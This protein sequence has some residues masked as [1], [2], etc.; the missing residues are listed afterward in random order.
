MRLKGLFSFLNRT[1]L[2][3][4]LKPYECEAYDKQLGFGNHRT[5]TEASAREWMKMYPACFDVVVWKR[6]QRKDCRIIAER[7]AA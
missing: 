2:L 1:K 3:N 4:L 7:R 6:A 5:F